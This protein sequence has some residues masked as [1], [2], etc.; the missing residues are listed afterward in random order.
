MS[1]LSDLSQLLA[2]MRPVLHDAPY[3]YALA[4]TCPSGA[5]ACVAEDEGLTV[6]ALHSV[7]ASADIDPGPAWARISLTVHSDLAAVGLTAALSKALAAQGISANIVAGF[8]HDHIFLPWDRRH[9]ALS[10]L[11]EL[12][13]A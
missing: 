11:T 3:G 10:A 7:L 12:S 13:N 2:T 5:F 6:V 1:G 8:H 9:D 4:A